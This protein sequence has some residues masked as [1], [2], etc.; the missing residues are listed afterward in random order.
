MDDKDE[1]PMPQKNQNPKDVGN[2]KM[3]R[4]SGLD[5]ATVEDKQVTFISAHSGAEEEDGDDLSDTEM[6]NQ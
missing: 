4:K 2:K 3:R 6:V 5:L 1:S